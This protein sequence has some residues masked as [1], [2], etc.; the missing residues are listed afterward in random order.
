MSI[1]M[2]MGMGSGMGSGSSSGSSGMTS[3]SSMMTV[4]FTATNTPLYSQSWTPSSLG[5]YTGTCVFCVILATVF[6]LILA[7]KARVESRWLDAELRR[8]Y[9]VVPGKPD[10]SQRISEDPSSK[11]MT[12]SENGVEEDVVVLTKRH[13]EVRPWRISID[14]LRALLDTLVAGIGYLLMIAV[15]S[16]NVGYFLSVLGGT[17]LGSLLV[18]RYV[19]IM[20]H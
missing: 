15:M 1:K 20:E 2:D 11:R 6:R 8:R 9:V 5:T 19:S 17:F 12:L 13:D 3:S 10:M 7:F 18:G 16:M 4:F 14:P